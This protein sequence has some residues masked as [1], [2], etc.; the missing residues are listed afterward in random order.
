MSETSTIPR[1]IQIDK[2]TP[3]EKA[4]FDALEEVEKT[5]IDVRLTEAV[6]LL[7]AAQNKVADFVDGVCL[8][9]GSW[10]DNHD[11]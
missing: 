4:I 5:G 8:K 11:R 2:F 9:P 3:A 6:N 7:K 10:E 1:R